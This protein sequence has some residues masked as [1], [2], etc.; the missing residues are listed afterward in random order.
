MV[1]LGEPGSGKS[2]FARKLLAM[3][4]NACLKKEE[5]LPGISP[6]LLPLLLK[7]ADIAPRLEEMTDAGLD[8]GRGADSFCQALQAQLLDDLRDDYRVPQFGKGLAMREPGAGVA[9]AGRLDDVREGARTS[10]RNA[11]WLS[12]GNTRFQLQLNTCRVRSYVEDAVIPVIPFFPCWNLQMSSPGISARLVPR[13]GKEVFH[14]AN[15]A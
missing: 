4:A 6:H 13:P 5:A 9:G 1:L 12:A 7:L 15:P 8:P 2:T 11:L 14:K 10:V 3:Q